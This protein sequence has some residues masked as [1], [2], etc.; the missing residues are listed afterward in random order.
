MVETHHLASRVNH[1]IH[2]LVRYLHFPML[3]ARLTLIPLPLQHSQI[4]LIRAPPP[5]TLPHQ[6]PYSINTITSAPLQIIWLIIPR[7]WSLLHSRIPPHRRKR[8]REKERKEWKREKGKRRKKKRKKRRERRRRG[9]TARRTKMINYTARSERH[10]DLARSTW[11]QHAAARYLSA[12]FTSWL[13]PLTRRAAF[14]FHGELF[15]WLDRFAAVDRGNFHVM[16][17]TEEYETRKGKARREVEEWP[18][19]KLNVLTSR[20]R[21][22]RARRECLPE[23]ILGTNWWMFV[24]LV[25]ERPS[26][27]RDGFEEWS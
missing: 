12:W 16:I 18:S 13:K 15:E 23:R 3:F 4:S 11:R 25:G 10:V 8:K 20:R 2:F 1:L 5:I 7:S 14:P 17:Y 6:S 24:R 26:C 19:C 21:F 9:I 27:I 22:L